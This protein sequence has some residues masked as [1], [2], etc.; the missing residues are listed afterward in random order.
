MSEARRRPTLPLNEETAREALR[1]IQSGRF[2]D[3]AI[4]R[5]LKVSEST[6]ND[7]HRGRKW[8]HLTVDTSRP[9][10]KAEAIFRSLSERPTDA[11]KRWLALAVRAIKSVAMVK[12]EFTADDVWN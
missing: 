9:R 5:K 11:A 8:A 2:T 3:A 6:I 12:D 10:S 7:V 1:L 4:A